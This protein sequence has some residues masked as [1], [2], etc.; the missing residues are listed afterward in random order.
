MSTIG[1]M[2]QLCEP[3]VNFEI[4]VRISPGKLLKYYVSNVN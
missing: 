4:E 2:N 3:Q 1:V